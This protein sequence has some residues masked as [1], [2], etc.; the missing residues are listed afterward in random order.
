MDGLQRQRL[1]IRERNYRPYLWL[2]NANM[3]LELLINTIVVDYAIKIV[4]DRTKDDS[5]K[6]IEEEERAKKKLKSPTTSNPVF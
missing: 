4:S 1:K 3:K 6:Q 2:K 5:N